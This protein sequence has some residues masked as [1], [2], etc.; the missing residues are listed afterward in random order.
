[1][2]LR[3]PHPAQMGERRGV[4][5]APE[6]V[7]QGPWRD[8]D[9]RGDLGDGDRLVGVVVDIGEGAAQDPGVPVARVGVRPLDERGVGERGQHHRRQVLYG[10][11]RHQGLL[12]EGRVVEH[13]VAQIADGARQLAAGLGRARPVPG[14]PD[15]PV[16]VA[17]HKAGHLGQQGGIQH[18]DGVARV[19]YSPAERQV[20][21]G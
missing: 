15:R 12:G 18:G 7:L 6:R 9:G 20:G 8:M 1:M 19:A 17:R 4:Q 5:M 11:G 16:V 13:V 10:R 14:E 21:R 3:Q 2:G